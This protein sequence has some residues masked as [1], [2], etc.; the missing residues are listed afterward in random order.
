MNYTFQEPEKNK[1][2]MPD[3]V[4]D[5]M[6][7]ATASIMKEFEE[8]GSDKFMSKVPGH[9]MNRDKIRKV[10]VPKLPPHKSNSKKKDYFFVKIYHHISLIAK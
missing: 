4:K 9:E 3:M 7:P 5:A 6:T 1:K 10:E 8:T 2:R